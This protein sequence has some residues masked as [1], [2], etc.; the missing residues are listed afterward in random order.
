MIRRVHRKDGFDHLDGCVP[1]PSLEQAF[2]QCVQL[3]HGIRYP[4]RLAVF[5]RQG[6]PQEVLLGIVIDQL[7]QKRNRIGAPTGRALLF[8]APGARLRMAA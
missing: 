1:I 2:A 3:G 4:F 8:T 7:F 5:L 6:T